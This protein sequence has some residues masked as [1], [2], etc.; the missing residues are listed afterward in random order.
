MPMLIA[1]A[2]ALVVAY[3]ALLWYGIGVY[4]V[5][6][7]A[8]SAAQLPAIGRVVLG[9]GLPFPWHAVVWQVPALLALAW[10]VAGA[11]AGAARSAWPLERRVLALATGVLALTLLAGVA[12]LAPLVEFAAVLRR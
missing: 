11:R 1:L 7:A 6:L 3:A 12:M 5:W 2:A 10:V 9:V 8:A 4:G